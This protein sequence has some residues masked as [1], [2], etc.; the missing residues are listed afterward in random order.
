[1]DPFWCISLGTLVIAKFWKREKRKSKERKYYKEQDEKRNE[2]LK[3]EAVIA[4]YS[5]VFGAP[6]TKEEQKREDDI[7]DLKRQG[8]DDELIAII[9]PT[10]NNGQ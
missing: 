9:L 1:M 2:K 4:K 5:A 7:A 8:Y 10:I 6:M 3:Q